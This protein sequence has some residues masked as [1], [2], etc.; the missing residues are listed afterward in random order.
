MTGSTTKQPP[1]VKC[2]ANKES[3]SPMHALQGFMNHFFKAIR[4]TIQELEKNSEWQSRMKEVKTKVSEELT[5]DADFLCCRKQQ[6][7]FHQQI[8]KWTVKLNNE[9]AKPLSQQN[10]ANI[11]AW[12][13]LILSKQE[14]RKLHVTTSGH[15][16]KQKSVTHVHHFWSSSRHMKHPKRNQ[17]AELNSYSTEQ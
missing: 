6:L 1:L 12:R 8:K 14:E 16:H 10:Q 17:K 13:R 3:M 5:G 9:K 7:F 15:G 11:E 2:P 4:G